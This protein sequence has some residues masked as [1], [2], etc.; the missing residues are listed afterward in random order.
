MRVSYNWLKTYIDFPYSPEKLAKE[1]TMAGLEVEEVEYLG[2]GLDKNVIGQINSINKHPNADKLVICDVDI[3]SNNLQIITGAENIEVGANIPVAETG[4]VLPNGMK[5]E[6]TKLRG[7]PSYGMMCSQDELGLVED[8]QDGIMILSDEMRVGKGFV[9]EYGLNDYIYKLDLTPNYARCLGLIGIAREIRARLKD[10][11]IKY[12]ETSVET[13]D[14]QVQDLIKVNIEDKELCLRYTGRVIKNVEIGPSPKWMQRRL[15]AAGIRPVNNIVDITNYVLFEYNQPLHAFDYD[16]ISGKEIIVRRADKGEKLKTLDEAERKLD[17]DVLV[18]ADQEK[19]LGMAGVMG[20]FSSEVT[21]KT[22][23]VFLESAFFEPLNIRKTATNYNLHSEASHRFEREV[24]IESLIPAS[25]RAAYLMQKYAGGEVVDG[26]LDH[27][28]NKKKDKHIELSVDK[29]NKMLGLSLKSEQ[30]KDML[31]RLEFEVDDGKNL[32]VKVPTYRNDV[33]QDADLIEEIARMYGYNNIPVTRPPRKQQGGQSN[34]QVLRNLAKDF[35]RSFGLDEVINFS[36]IN[37]EIYDKMKIKED[38]RLRNWV[39]IK[40]PLSEAF[41]VMRTS[42]IPGIAEVLSKNAKR[43]VK[44]MSIF[45][46][47]KVFYNQGEGNRPKERR[48]LAGGSMGYEEDIWDNSAPDFFYLKG[49][50]QE[51]F[52]RIGLKNIKFTPKEISYFHPGRTAFIVHDDDIIGNIG[53]LLPNIIDEFDLAPGTTVFQLDYQLI[54]EKANYTDVSYEEMPNYPSVNRDL[55]V[56]VSED[57]AV[58]DILEVMKN[59]AGKLLESIELFDL[60]RGKPIPEGQ[61]SIA[62]Q[63]LFRSE[64]RTLTDDEVN[65]VFQSIIKTLKNELSAEIRGN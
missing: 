36:L 12:P 43:Q 41:A 47:G 5:I 20:G 45:E 14:E 18:I 30:I 40:N 33:E 24:D 19:A 29:A 51:F 28:P 53:E 46:M 56:I 39:E 48:V 7:E 9:Q 54:S 26:I 13:I 25:D 44:Q 16:K 35:M 52:N 59:T 64:D 34:Q 10:E 61:K 60:Y 37:R 63:L 42:L 8:R 23:N 58:V 50:L 1:L 32:R 3:G 49:I 27:Y 57:I 17:Q 55:A 2:E 31:E 15:E 6:A 11:E 4:V 38:S 22:K 21:D 62:F 65:K